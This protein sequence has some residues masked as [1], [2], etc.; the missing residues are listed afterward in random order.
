MLSCLIISDLS[1]VIRRSNLAIDLASCLLA[2]QTFISFSWSNVVHVGDGCINKP[3]AEPSF[4]LVVV[5]TGMEVA[6]VKC[7]MEWSADFCVWCVVQQRQQEGR[8]GS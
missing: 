3:L 4:C 6:L 1:K 2:Y 5:A 8:S 7:F